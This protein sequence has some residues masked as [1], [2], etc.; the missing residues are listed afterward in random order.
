MP[1]KVWRFSVF[2]GSL[3]GADEHLIGFA[4][5]GPTSSGT[6]ALLLRHLL[7]WLF[8][9]GFH[10]SAIPR[11]PLSSSSLTLHLLKHNQ[12]NHKTTI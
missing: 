12:I 2:L 1:D 10:K 11:P 6:R 7:P 4:I 3:A 8:F 5:N 9:P